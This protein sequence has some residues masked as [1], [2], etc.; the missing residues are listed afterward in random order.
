[1]QIDSTDIPV[2]HIKLR[3]MRVLYFRIYF[4]GVKVNN[5]IFSA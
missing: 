2:I 3:E 4:F 5:N 1:M